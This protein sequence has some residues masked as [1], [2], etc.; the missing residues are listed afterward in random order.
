MVLTAQ[1][2]EGCTN[3]NCKAKKQSTHTT[4]NC[5]WPG[6]GKEGQFPP[7]FG[8]W[9]KANTTT[10]TPM[11]TTSGTPTAGAASTTKQTKNF[12]LSV[13]VP[14][15]PGQSGVLIDAPTSCLSIALISKG[16]QN[17]GKEIPT[18]MDLEASNTMFV[19]QEV[20]TEYMPII[21][22]VGDSAKVVDSGFEIVSEGNVIQKY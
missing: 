17:F 3:P 2:S 14:D 1:T 21:L 8:Q 16:F 6:G 12:V 13:Q 22:Q 9:T 4:M 10:S 18:F 11:A 15:T 5:Y 7:S 20:F 19:S